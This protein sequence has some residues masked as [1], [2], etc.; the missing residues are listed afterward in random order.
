L[1]VHL[2]LPPSANHIWSHA[3]PTRA[4]PRGRIYRAEHYNTWL[5]LNLFRVGKRGAA[6]APPY[7]VTIAVHGGQGL[8]VTRR[9]LDNFAK[10]S[11]DFLKHCNVIVD[12]TIACIP[13][14]DLRYVPPPDPKQ[15]AYAVMS[16]EEIDYPGIVRA[17][18]IAPGGDGGTVGRAL[19]GDTGRMPALTIGTKAK[20]P[21]AK[22]RGKKR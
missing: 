11:I 18:P 15:R 16:V 3:G 1:T 5:R 12:D 22:K 10:A 21:T 13:D 7:K 17:V 6:L 8:D 19:S 9:D 20:L 4:R 2:T 14:L